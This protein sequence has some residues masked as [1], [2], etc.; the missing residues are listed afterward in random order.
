MIYDKIDL[1][2]EYNDSYFDLNSIL[3]TETD[4]EDID[5][6][7]KEESDNTETQEPGGN[8]NDD[9]E[10]TKETATL[11][12]I[13]YPMYLPVNTYLTSQEKVATAWMKKRGI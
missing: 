9:T 3:D 11:D 8:V 1:K 12:D 5:K 2:T 7:E 6:K 10:K 13:I 4:E